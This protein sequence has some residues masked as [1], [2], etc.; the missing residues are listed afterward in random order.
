MCGIVGYVGPNVDGKALD[1]VMEGLARLEYRG[2]D[3]AGVA[4]VTER[5]RG[6]ARSGPASSVNLRDALDA[7]PAARATTG[8]GHTRWATHGGPTDEN[9]HPHRGGDDGKLALIHNGIIENFHAAQEAE[10]AR[11]R[12]GSS[13][14]ETDTEVAAHLVARAYDET[15]DLTEAMRRSS[16][17][18]EG[19]FTLL[20]VH[21]DSPGRRR[22]RPPQQPARRRARRRRELP[23]LRRRG[24]H[25][26]HP[27]RARA[28]PGPDRHDHPRL[29]TSVINFDGAPPRASPTRSRGTPRP[30]R[31]AATPT[32]MEKEIHDQPHAVARHPARPHRPVDGRLVLDEHA[33]HRGPA[34][35]RRPHHR[36]S[37]AAPPPTPGMVAKYA[38]EHWT[39]IPVEVTLAH[40]FRY[41][42][43]I[44]DERTLVVVDQ[45]V[46]RDDGHADGGQARPRAGR[47]DPVDLQH[48]RVDHPARVRRG[49]LHARRPG[50]RRRVDQGVPR[51]DH[52]AAT[53][54]ASTSPSCAAARSPTTRRR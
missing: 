43:P 46:R 5:R 11:R 29:R 30:P 37:R 32:F 10:L 45:P 22:R 21:A 9:A 3:S 8:I 25:R 15:G 17:D 47:A 53:S 39:R 2:Y 52:R 7:A 13:T 33:D 41:C 48:P 4:L 23:R 26:P 50:D 28:R 38:I 19:A 1:V 34:A 35:Q 16:A 51:P 40:E 31:R 54:S 6:D 27:P 44:V 24:L 18:L 42:D 14:S 49:P 36:S 12:R 20:A